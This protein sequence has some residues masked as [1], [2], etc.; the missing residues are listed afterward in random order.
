MSVLTKYGKALAAVLAAALIA[1]SSAV[2]DGHVDAGEG[3]SIGIAIVTAMSVWLVPNLPQSPVIKTTVA[4]ILAGL[5]AASMLIVD[6][7]S[8]ADTINMVIA[9]LGVLGV[10]SAPAQSAG[11]D[12]VPRSVAGAATRPTYGST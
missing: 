4:V 1:L 11:D 12:L 5:N 3:V 8:T 6:G 7:W 2:T 9:A 10:L